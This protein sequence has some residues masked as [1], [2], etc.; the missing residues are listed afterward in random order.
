[1]TQRLDS[2][3]QSWGLLLTE[4]VLIVASILRAFSLESWWDE[5]EDGDE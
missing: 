1:M 3:L 2:R 5:G 4:M